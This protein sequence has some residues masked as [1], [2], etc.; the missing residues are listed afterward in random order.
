MCTLA[1]VWEQ[2]GSDWLDAVLPGQPGSRWNTTRSEHKE[3]EREKGGGEGE[4][5]GVGGERGC[6]G[7]ER[8]RES[9]TVQT[10][11]ERNRNVRKR[12]GGRERGERGKENR[13]CLI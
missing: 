10:K 1:C 3:R 6:R 11:E 9:V 12:D 5:G 8:K 7:R 4:R 2:M 13:I